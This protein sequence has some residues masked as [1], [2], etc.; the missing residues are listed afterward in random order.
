MS[1]EIGVA[2]VIDRATLEIRGQRI[3]LHGIDAAE[4]DQICVDA[5]GQ[6]WRGGQRAGGIAGP[7]RPAH[8]HV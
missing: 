1:A 2:S 5:A 6:K 8:R 3:R 7:H 4:S